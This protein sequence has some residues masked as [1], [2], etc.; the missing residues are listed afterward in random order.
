[1]NSRWTLDGLRSLLLEVPLL[2]RALVLSTVVGT[3]RPQ[4]SCIVN[5]WHYWS[6]WTKIRFGWI[7]NILFHAWFLGNWKKYM[8][9]LQIIQNTEVQTIT[10]FYFNLKLFW[11]RFVFRMFRST[12]GDFEKLKLLLQKSKLKT[13]TNETRTQIPDTRFQINQSDVYYRKHASHSTLVQTADS[14]LLSTYYYTQLPNQHVVD[15][16]SYSDL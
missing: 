3:W 6:V 10:A 5:V 2:V 4:I 11:R 16:S 14:S 9:G 8:K 7:D 15:K 12:F 13:K 1:M